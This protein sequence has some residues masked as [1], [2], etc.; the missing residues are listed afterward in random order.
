MGLLPDVETHLTRGFYKLGW[1][2]GQSPLWTLSLLTIGTL[3]LFCGLIK[4]EQSTDIRD[5]VPSDAE[6]RYETK[7]AERFARVDKG[8][9][10]SIQ[11]VGY[12]KDGGNLLRTN[13]SEQLQSFVDTA[14]ELSVEKDG[15][16]F[17]YKS[18]CRPYC[19]VNT[20]LT[21]FLQVFPVMEEPFHYPQALV[22]GTPLYIGNNIFEVTTD[23]STGAITGFG[24]A[25]IRFLVIVEN[26]KIVMAWE[27]KVKALYKDYDLLDLILWS[28][29]LLAE[30]IDRLGYSTAPLI[31]LSVLLLITFFLLTSMRAD[32][33]RSKPWE[34][35]IGILVPVIAIGASFGILAMCG[36]KMQPIIVATLFLVLSV[37]TDDAFIMM[38]AWDRT[39]DH[40]RGPPPAPRDS[41]SSHCSTSTSSSLEEVPSIAERT[42]E[43]LAE[44]GSSIAIT[45]LTNM[46]SFGVGIF[47]STPAIRALCI[48]STAAIFAC[49]VYQITLYTAV[50]ALSGRR[51][52]KRLSSIW[53]CVKAGKNK[54]PQSPAVQ[55]VFRFANLAHDTFFDFIIKISKST[56]FKV[57]LCFTM[58]A[59][60]VGSCYSLTNLRSD[61]T[62]NKL[63]LPDSVLI[64]FQERL[65]RAQSEMQILS[66][67]VTKPSDLR[68][69]DNRLR[70]KRM[71]KEFEHAMFS[72]GKNSTLFW[73]ADY[74][75]YVTMMSDDQFTYTELPSFLDT[76]GYTHWKAFV[77]IH[78]REC[79]KDSP[80]CVDSFL[81]NTGF[82]SVVRFYERVPQLENWRKIASRYSEMGVVPFNE[83]SLF[84]DQSSSI[85]FTVESSLLAALAFMAVSCLLFIP[86]FSL[87][88]FAIISIASVNIGVF[89]VLVLC[90]VELDPL[91][92]AAMLMSVGFS[93][94]YTAH[95][96]YHFYKSEE[97]TPEG[98]LRFALSAIGWP[99]IQCALSTILAVSPLLLK[100]SYIAHVFF[101]TVVFVIF[102]GV[103]HGLV[104]IPALLLTLPQE[105]TGKQMPST[106]STRSSECGDAPEKP[107]ILPSLSATSLHDPEAP[108][109][110]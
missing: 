73:L 13:H 1:R 98:K 74:E 68:K 10:Y 96:T 91:S 28:D 67:F 108:M 21:A 2:I 40:R 54:S 12:A 99:M 81:L 61:L 48:Y 57:A 29:G 84:T 97:L 102:I 95:I 92:M 51:E 41:T 79:A 53:C 44:S 58:V 46:L 45:T 80:K 39:I 11:I 8:S 47:S 63:A 105:C 78:E 17:T 15:E 107:A 65:E 49:F 35:L 26:P 62:V 37:G 5:F 93:V 22:Y 6:S 38:R 110:M 55:A 59:Y 14:M 52:S 7:V 32:S 24:L 50:I 71:V 86:S 19:E 88:F 31:G 106:C 101:E 77:H 87:V 100:P 89:G 69:E 27:E 70:T 90:G 66:V 75:E 94:D 30:E 33:V 23:N 43:M 82:T 85:A 9:F 34:A 60:W 104:F 72:Y 36:I 42:A 64:K 4:L 83:N 56:S 20:P 25:V 103:F 109:K 3:I 16:T 18:S 76:P